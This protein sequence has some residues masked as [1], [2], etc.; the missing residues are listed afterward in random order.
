MADGSHSSFVAAPSRRPRIAW[1]AEAVER[2]REAWERGGVVAARA[3]F[4]GVSDGALGVRAS[5]YG[6]K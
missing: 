6:F 5:Y 3:A 1:T 4:P 2:L